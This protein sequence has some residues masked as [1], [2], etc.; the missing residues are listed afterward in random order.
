LQGSAMSRVRT[1]SLQGS[2]M[3]RSV[4]RWPP[5]TESCDHSEPS[6]CSIFGRQ[7]K[8][9]VLRFSP[10][11]VIPS[12]LCDHILLICHRHCIVLPVDGVDTTTLLKLA[13]SLP[14]TFIVLVLSCCFSVYW[15]L[16][17]WL[18]C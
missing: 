17:A 7:A 14:S 15:Q 4:S 9:Q 8:A 11:T 6:Q 5:T 3:A 12:V 10:V 13:S 18:N 16:N 1:A 2:A